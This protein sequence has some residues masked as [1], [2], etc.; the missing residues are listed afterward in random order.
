[1]SNHENEIMIKLSELLK[2]S[3]GI[4]MPEV[5]SNLT[6]APP[7]NPA[8]PMSTSQLPIDLPEQE[9]GEAEPTEEEERAFQERQRRKE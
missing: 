4:P 8:A 2:K 1:M 5:P 9:Q 6:I 3:V 7:S